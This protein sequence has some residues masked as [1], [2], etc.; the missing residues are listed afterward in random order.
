MGPTEEGAS[1]REWGQPDRIA[2]SRDDRDILDD[3]ADDRKQLPDLGR[4]VNCGCTIKLAGPATPLCATCRA[5][6][7]WYRASRLAS[8]HLREAH[9]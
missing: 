6:H 5:W 8:R 9:R 2:E 4:C 3:H 1:G 7:R